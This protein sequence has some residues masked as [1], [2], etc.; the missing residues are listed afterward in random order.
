MD[1]LVKIFGLTLPPADR[2]SILAGPG[3]PA[4]IQRTLAT[5]HRRSKRLPMYS[6]VALLLSSS[7]AFGQY[8]PPHE[9]GDVAPADMGMPKHNNGYY[10]IIYGRGAQ[11]WSL[12]TVSDEKAGAWNDAQVTMVQDN[13]LL[14]SGASVPW[15]DAVMVGRYAVRAFKDL[16]G[17]FAVVCRARRP[18]PTCGMFDALVSGQMRD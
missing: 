13:A 12:A 9:I 14:D 11:S 10:R 8:T 17:A 2:A 16:R 15:E 18:L 7:L 3:L 4:A 6:K 1:L 5:D